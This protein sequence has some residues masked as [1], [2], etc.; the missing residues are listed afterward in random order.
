MTVAAQILRRYVTERA[1]GRTPRHEWAYYASDIG[2]WIRTDEA[3]ARRHEDH[4]R[5]RKDG[6]PW[7]DVL[8][9]RTDVRDD[10]ALQ[11]FFLT[12]DPDDWP[13]MAS[14]IREH[15][16]RCLRDWTTAGRRIIAAV[17]PDQTSA[18]SGTPGPLAGWPTARGTGQRSMLPR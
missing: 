8:G 1:S 17:T 14:A 2:A 10:H 9:H 3:S 6:V 15:P 18:V 16:R 11:V 4:R 12:I 5:I 13:R 7:C